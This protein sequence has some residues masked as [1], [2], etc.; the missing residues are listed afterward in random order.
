MQARAVI[1]IRWALHA[2]VVGLALW[3]A[4][5]LPDDARVAQAWAAALGL[6]AVYVAGVALLPELRDARSIGGHRRTLLRVWFVLVLLAWCLLLWLAP[7]AAYIAFPLFFLSLHLHGVVLGL[8]TVALELVASVFGLA[9]HQGALTWPL[10]LGPTLGAAVA[11]ATVITFD[12]LV[13]ESNHRQRLITE[14]EATRADLASAQHDAGV[15]AERE[16]LAAEIHD[17]LA[18]QFQGISLLLASAERSLPADPDRAGEWVTQARE[19]SLAG[20]A[21][22]RQLVAALVPADLTHTTLPAA[23]ERLAARTST[24]DLRVT[25]VDER[26]GRGLSSEVEVVLLRVAQSALANVVHHAGAARCTLTLT[27]T[28]LTVTDDG[29]GFDPSARRPGYGLD[30]M[31]RRL[32]TVGGELT[33]DSDDTG[34]RLVAI[35]GND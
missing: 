9:H 5:A 17:T 8:A 23:L 1:W 35:V 18:Q 24:P 29:H 33:I 27:D 10:V 14:L 12:S 3:S 26:S 21:E 28:G 7:V 22:A 16:R 31:R 4:I 25:F 15:M 2:L 34:T 19:S 30:V 6:V 13:A 20:L 32:A 11:A